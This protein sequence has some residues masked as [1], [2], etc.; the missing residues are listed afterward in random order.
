MPR[1]AAHVAGRIDTN[2]RNR[3]EDAISFKIT[4]MLE[5]AASL[6]GVALQVKVALCAVG[7]IIGNEES[8]K[9]ERKGYFSNSAEVVKVVNIEQFVCLVTAFKVNIS[10]LLPDPRPNCAVHTS[11]GSGARG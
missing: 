9:E 6:A 1:C 7:L 4:P 10:D 5:G 2:N 11:S 3:P 8:V